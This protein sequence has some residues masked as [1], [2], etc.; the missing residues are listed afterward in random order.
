LDAQA[1]TL[2]TDKIR[3]KDMTQIEILTSKMGKYLTVENS[4]KFFST[5]FSLHEM[6]WS[7]LPE[8]LLRSTLECGAAQIQRY[9]YKPHL[10]ETQIEKIQ[11]SS[12]D[13]HKKIVI[14]LKA[15]DKDTLA[16]LFRN[17]WIHPGVDFLDKTK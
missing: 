12:F 4:Q 17:H 3:A 1:I 6:I 2:V 14:A 9:S 8:G 5:N 10:S 11:E 15:Q 7:Y 16:N 13:A